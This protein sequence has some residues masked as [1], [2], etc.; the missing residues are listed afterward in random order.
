VAPRVEKAN[1]IPKKSSDE[2]NHP[3]ISVRDLL[4]NV[5]AQIS[6]E[7]Q[8]ADESATA[9]TGKQNT[10]PMFSMPKNIR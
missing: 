9:D 7:K 3:Y 8:K 10:P 1:L 5:Q 4:K 6:R 2:V